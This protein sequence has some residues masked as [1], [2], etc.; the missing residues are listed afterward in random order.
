MRRGCVLTIIVISA[1][2]FVLAVV[3]FVFFWPKMKRLETSKIAAAIEIKLEE[4]KSDQGIYPPG[5]GGNGQVMRALHL[6]DN[7]RKKIYLKDAYVRD[8]QLIDFWKHPLSIEFPPDGKPRVT[9][10]GP[11]GE[12]GDAD[13]I[14]SQLIR[15]ELEKHQKNR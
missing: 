1:I 14:T 13:D 4:F 12:F 9:S 15:D 6:G 8:G 11:N 10:A 5:A 2:V 7:P 3:S